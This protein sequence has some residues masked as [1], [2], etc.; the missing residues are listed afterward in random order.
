MEVNNFFNLPARLTRVGYQSVTWRSSLHLTP[1]FWGILPWTRP[2][3]LTP[4]SQ[5]LPLCPRRGQL[6]PPLLGLPPLSVVTMVK[7]SF[8]R[9]KRKQ[10]S[11]IFSQEV[12]FRRLC[13]AICY[14]FKTP[15][16]QRKFPD[17]ITSFPENWRLRSSD[18]RN[19]ILMTP[20]WWRV[21]TQANL[22]SASN[23]SC[24]VGNLLQPIK[25]ASLIWVVTRHQYGISSLVSQTSF[26]SF[27]GK[28]SG[29]VANSRLSFHCFVIEDYV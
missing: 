7:V 5:R 20:Y 2:T 24:R 22:G 11:T 9:L 23:W 28:T 6:Y 27:N 26:Q 17:A 16:Q 10:R 4:P 8:H 18:G 3:P 21:T 25:G 12:L 13:E 19:S 29:D 14:L 15:R 1:V